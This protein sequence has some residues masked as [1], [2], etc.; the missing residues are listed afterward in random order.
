MYATP[1]DYEKKPN[2]TVGRFRPMKTTHRFKFKSNGC[3]GQINAVSEK[4]LSPIALN[5]ISGLITNPK[6]D[7]KLCPWGEEE[8]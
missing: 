7:F 2:M 4:R 5:E 1:S 8:I 6:K 3:M